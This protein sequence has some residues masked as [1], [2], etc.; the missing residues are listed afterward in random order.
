VIRGAGEPTLPT[1]ADAIRATIAFRP[2]LTLIGSEELFVAN[3]GDTGDPFRACGVDR[4][5]MAQRLR[6][7]NADLGLVI[8]LNFDAIPALAAIE[9]I[10]A[11]DAS[12]AGS[13]TL[14]LAQGA[15]SR[16]LR[17]EIAILFDRAGF[18]QMARVRVK[19]RPIQ[20]RVTFDGDSGPP[21]PSCEGTGECV[22]F[23]DPGDHVVRTTL[24]GYRAASTPVLA[25]RGE[26]IAVSVFLES[27]PSSDETPLFES[28]WF[29][30]AVGTVAIAG[31]ITLY[32]VLR[33]VRDCICIPTPGVECPSSC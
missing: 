28:L 27:D 31:A 32:F 12:V 23:T 10:R 2:D 5:R 18:E 8:V 33:P 21:N 9:L 7:A 22:H 17:E 6:A 16:R 13:F 19:V 30:G 29:W 24:A 1:I 3:P 25:N 11:E 4:Q 15:V 20:A 14:D 26:E